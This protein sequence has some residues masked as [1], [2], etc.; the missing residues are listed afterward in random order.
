MQEKAPKNM[1]YIRS[2][3]ETIYDP[4]GNFDTTNI[5]PGSIESLCIQWC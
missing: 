1:L 3:Q 5:K 2:L 4:D